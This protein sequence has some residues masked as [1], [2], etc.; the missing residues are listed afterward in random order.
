MF[1]RG[2]NVVGLREEVCLVDLSW[3]VRRPFAVLSSLF[4]AF[5]RVCRTASICQWNS[6]TTGCG[7]RYSRRIVLVPFSLFTDDV[8]RWC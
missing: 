4:V 6:V 3:F 2:E 5:D 1:S 7:S 8:L